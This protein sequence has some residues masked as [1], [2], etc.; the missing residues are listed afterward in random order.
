MTGEA[1]PTCCCSCE[2]YKSDGYRLDK[3]LTLV[4]HG[5]H[6]PKNPSE[7]PPTN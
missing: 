4:Y 1:E 2:H 7:N 3:C 5:S 6:S